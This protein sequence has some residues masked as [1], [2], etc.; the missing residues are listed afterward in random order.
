M[1]N[2]IIYH[3]DDKASNNN[4]GYIDKECI[5]ILVKGLQKYY[6]DKPEYGS[7]ELIKSFRE[8]ID[9]C[10]RKEQSRK[11]KEGIRKS[12]ERKT[13]LQNNTSNKNKGV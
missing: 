2:K 12:R 13:A 5:D 11:I 7:E 3:N 4:K 9:L 8:F 6:E 1:N 10:Y